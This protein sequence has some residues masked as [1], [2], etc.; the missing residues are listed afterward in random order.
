MD[1]KIITLEDEAFYSLL[2]KVVA[3]VKADLGERALDQWIDGEEAMHM[4][5]IKSPTTLQ[6][7]RD[8]GAIRYSQPLHKVILYDRESILEFIERH[9]KNTF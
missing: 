6:K 8:S 2:S 3:Q 4:L 5:R 7:L 1:L 9:V